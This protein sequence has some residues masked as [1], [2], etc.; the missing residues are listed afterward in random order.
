[1]SNDNDWKAIRIAEARKSNVNINEEVSATIFKLLN[2]ELT[3]RPFNSKELASIS[4][5]ILAAMGQISPKVEA[6]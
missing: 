3:E 5:D 6:K 4:G 1:M 2:G